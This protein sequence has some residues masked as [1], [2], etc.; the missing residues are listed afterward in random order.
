[1]GSKWALLCSG[2]QRTALGRGVLP[3]RGPQRVTMRPRVRVRSQ[4]IKSQLVQ[5]LKGLDVLLAPRGYATGSAVACSAGER[6][7][8]NRAG[9]IRGTGANN[10]AK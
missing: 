10:G 4:T 3:L 9:V 2:A 7:L 1:M 5:N 6:H 8:L